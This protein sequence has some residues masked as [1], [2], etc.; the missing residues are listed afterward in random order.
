MVL[1]LFFLCFFC[2]WV[3]VGYFYVLNDGYWC[4]QFG[5]YVV[6]IYFF[7]EFNRYSCLLMSFVFFLCF[8]CFLLLR[9][10]LPSL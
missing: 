9:L 8:L 7:S 2:Y 1:D 5:F 6:V 10:L 3:W 4:S